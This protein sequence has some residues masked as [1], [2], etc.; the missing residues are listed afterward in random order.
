VFRFS[1]PSELD[2]A[3]AARALGF[4]IGAEEV[5]ALT[6]RVGHFLDM[7]EVIDD[8]K[9]EQDKPAVKY[10]RRLPAW[11]PSI[12]EDPL[13]AFIHRCRIE[14]APDGPLA[15]KTVGLKDHIAVAGV[16]LTLGA[17]A[18]EGYVPDHDATVVT[19]LL[20]AG[21]TIVGKLNMDPF[22]LAGA[23][24]GGL[25]DY[26]RVLNPQT[27]DCLTGGS[28]SGSAAA[29]AGDV[30]IAIGG[31]QG[32][33]IRIPSAWC[34]VVGLKPTWGLVP[35][36]GVIGLEPTFD[37]IGPMARTVMDVAS[38][39]ECI[40]GPDS[41]DP[42]QR[43]VPTEVPRYTERLSQGVR[44]VRVGVLREGFGSESPVAAVVRTAIDKLAGMGAS[45]EN[46]SIPRHRE[47]GLVGFAAFAAGITRSVLGT[48]LGGA[49]AKT[50]YPTDLVAYVGRLKQSGLWELPAYVKL[51][52]IVDAFADRR[53]HGTL[54]A[55]AN[56]ARRPITTMYDDAFRQVD[57][58]A[59]P[60]ILVTAPRY[61]EPAT[62]REA[63]E[64]TVRASQRQRR[65]EPVGHSPNTAVFDFTGHPALSVPCGLVDGMPV[66]LQVVGSF[67]GEARLLQVAAAIEALRLC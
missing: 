40:A 26:G 61:E 52:L 55:K 64:Q 66:G 4:P 50:F 54:A 42:R 3:G 62:Y 39:L 33:S 36:T 5:E 29:A 14:G 60:T 27:H 45:V 65:T 21:A 12:H 46:V 47:S 13:N 32:G 10:A 44:G 51:L 31:D 18:M 35:H 41:Y 7:L 2:V 15:G 48:N 34:G 43:D 25:S 49:D 16:P 38:A 11:R 30:D 58:L 67:F 19:R 37:H 24:F 53:Y 8:M 1:P 17:R 57:V 6:E 9:L 56:N 63:Y 28:S 20:D 59:M 22:S 23:G